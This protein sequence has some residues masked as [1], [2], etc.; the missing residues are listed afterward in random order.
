M[1]IKFYQ[2]VK[3]ITKKSSWSYEK[4]QGQLDKKYSWKVFIQ[5]L[6]RIDKFSASDWLSSFD[7]SFL[8]PAT[9]IFL[10]HFEKRH[11]PLT[12][13]TKRSYNHW[14]RDEFTFKVF[15]AFYQNNLKLFSC[16]SP[17]S[18]VINFFL[19]RIK[20]VLSY[21]CETGRYMDNVSWFQAK[22]EWFH[23]NA[24]R[25]KATENESYF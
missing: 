5:F 4:N 19:F 21:F 22:R 14:D 23:W 25:K 15:F 16:L 12:I 18:R 9:A 24:D 13:I 20:H 11:R 3:K 7:A 2:E 6:L 8:F 10:E 17:L 1:K